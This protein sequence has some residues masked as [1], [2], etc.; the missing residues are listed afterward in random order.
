[1]K[2]K[3]LKHCKPNVSVTKNLPSLMQQEVG[4][5]AF[6]YGRFLGKFNDFVSVSN[7]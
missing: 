2:E 6:V 5:I 7:I 1:M 3:V 4:F